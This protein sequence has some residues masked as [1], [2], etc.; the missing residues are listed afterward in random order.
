MGSLHARV[1]SQSDVA[2]L[3]WVLDT[4]AS[5]GA[6]V[7]DRYGARPV[8]DTDSFDG[9]DAVIVA[10]PTERHHHWAMRSL[11]AGIPTL[12]EKPV[13]LDLE[14]TESLVELSRRKDVPISAGFVERFNPAVRTALDIVLD[15][16]YVS[17][18]RHSPYVPRIKTGVAP[19]LL[20]HDA[21]LAIALAG[22]EPDMVSA[23]FLQCHA[24]SVAEDIVEARLAFGSGAIASLS[25]SRIAQRKIRNITV[26]ALDVSADIDL[27][28]QDVT[29]YRHVGNMALEMDGPGYRQETIIDIPVIRYR[30]EPL[31]A[32]LEHFAALCR[33]E[34][35]VEAERS[36]ILPAHRVLDAVLR[37]VAEGRAVS[38][39]LGTAGS[40]VDLPAPS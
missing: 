19:D 9:V 21:D 38:Y 11:E 17:A 3:V 10:A 7:A 32:Q 20:I 8:L 5:R 25:A 31:A 6:A 4:D 23:S 33:G 29:I 1:V 18:V 2:S 30:G 16:V 36:G 37:S 28:R 15:P 34:V 13:T 40:A 35:D 24:D 12:I 26:A 22:R 14:V 39:A 27:L